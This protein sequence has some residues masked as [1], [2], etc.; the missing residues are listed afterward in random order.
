MKYPMI[1]L[2]LARFAT[3]EEISTFEK[4]D[5]L[6]EKVSDENFDNIVSAISDYA[7]DYQGSRKYYQRVYRI[8]KKLGLETS[9]LMLWYYVEN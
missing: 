1:E 2:G 6:L 8:A 5:A 3:P 7:F 4:V 9:E